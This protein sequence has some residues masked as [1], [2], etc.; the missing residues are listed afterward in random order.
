M[1]GISGQLDWF[2]HPFSWHH[3]LDTGTAPLRRRPFTQAHW[4]SSV[5]KAGL[6]GAEPTRVGM[7]MMI[8]IL[9][10]FDRMTIDELHREREHW[11]R[12]VREATDVSISL[13]VARELLARCDALIAQRGAA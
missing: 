9:K 10:P 4:R 7:A 11:D 12:Y 13:G 6:G 1:R 3:S 2:D 8:T 5:D